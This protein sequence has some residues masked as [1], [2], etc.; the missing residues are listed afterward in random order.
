MRAQHLSAF[1]TKFGLFLTTWLLEEVIASWHGACSTYPELSIVRRFQALN[2][3]N[4]L[5]L[6]SELSSME[7]KFRMQE[8]L[9]RNSPNEQ[10]RWNTRSWTFLQDG[11]DGDEGEGETWRIFLG[12]REKFK[13]YSMQVF[14]FISSNPELRQMQR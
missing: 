7:K 4:L 3:Q 6:Q 14:T 10:R 2:F 5:Y 13:E 9:D 8:A 12:L 11:I 1:L